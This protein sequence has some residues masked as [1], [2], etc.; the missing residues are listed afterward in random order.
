[1]STGG[2]LR[3]ASEAAESVTLRVSVPDEILPNMRQIDRRE[4][5]LWSSAISVT[6]LLGLGIASFAVPVLMAGIDSFDA[7]A[8]NQAVRG[9]IGLVLVFNVYVIY[10]QLQ[11]HRIRREFSDSLYK[12]AVLDPVTHMFNRR[13]I[14]HRLREEI[15]RSQ[16]YGTPLTLLALDLDCF[17]QIND[18]YG[19]AVGD[20]VLKSF[21]ESLQ[22][23]TRG[24]DVVGR[25]GGDEFVAIL[26]ET[27]AGQ[28]RYVLERLNGLR[29]KTNGSMIAI[30]YSVGCTD[31]IL[32]ESVEDL[33]KRAD[34]MLYANKRNPKGL[35]I[36]SP[37]PDFP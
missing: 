28:M 25:Y 21:G 36:S 22:R 7:F 24:S 1:M 5:W 16:R 37:V 26:P 9:L 18:E 35:F 15:A 4:W 10:E 29:V 13:Y 6:L 14:L 30:R 8:L 34:E 11:I 2:H 20:H 12:M 3:P 23:A 33:L 27:T 19:H 32:G 17:K 31:Y